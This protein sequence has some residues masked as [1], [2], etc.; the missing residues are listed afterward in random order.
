MRN[1]ATSNI[2]DDKNND[3][4]QHKEGRIRSTHAAYALRIKN[5]VQ[6]KNEDN[7]EQESV[8]YE[9]RYE[10]QG[11]LERSKTIIYNPM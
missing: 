2:Q 9:T 4:V 5:A 11:N 7:I 10:F 3:E 1:A 6:A 8:A